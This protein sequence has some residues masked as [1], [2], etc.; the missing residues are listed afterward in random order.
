MINFLMRSQ[1]KLKINSRQV[2]QKV[3]ATI[4]QIINNFLSFLQLKQWVIFVQ[5][6][7]F[8]LPETSK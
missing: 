7:S 2:E 5:W 1:S 3:E 8:P 6:V 4:N